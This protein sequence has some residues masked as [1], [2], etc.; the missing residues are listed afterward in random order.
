MGLAP[1][2]GLLAAFDLSAAIRPAYVALMCVGAVIG[3]VISAVLLGMI[4]FGMFTPVG[5]LF[6]LS[7]RDPMERKIDKSAKS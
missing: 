4:Y 5:L 6:R 2:L 3:F 1:K 7:G